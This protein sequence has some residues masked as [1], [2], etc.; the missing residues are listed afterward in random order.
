MTD[1]HMRKEMSNKLVDL[2]DL[3]EMESM[4]FLS[5]RTLEK[6]F[7][8]DGEAPTVKTWRNK[9]T[10]E[11]FQIHKSGLFRRTGIPKGRE[12]LEYGEWERGFFGSSS[13]I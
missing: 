4:E 9:E 1:A 7:L 6:P 3:I 13:A 2:T 10:K 12:V 5:E 11:C 8:L